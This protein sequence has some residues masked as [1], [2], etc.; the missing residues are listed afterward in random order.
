MPSDADRLV[1]NPGDSVGQHRVTRLIGRGGMGSVY[2][3][4]HTLLGRTVAIKVLL[5]E[6][7]QNADIVQRFFNEARATTAIHHPGIVEVF[8][9]G[10]TS[11]GAAYIVMEY[12]RGESLAARIESK[13]VSWA[14]AVV[15]MRQLA[16]VLAAAHAQG[17]V[18][19]DL[20]PDN[21][22]LVSDPEVPGGE[23]V[24]LLDFG[25][26][27]LLN[28][29]ATSNPTRTGSVLGTPTYMAP[30]QCRGVT[31]DHRA[32]LYAVGCVLFEL[33]TGRPPFDGEGSGDI[34]AAHIHV[35]PPLT[36]RF[37]SGVPADLEALVQAL[38]VKQPSQRLQTANELV[39]AIDGL[40]S[41]GTGAHAPMTVVMPTP[42]PTM[43]TTLSGAASARSTPPSPRN[44]YLTVGI[45]AVLATAAAG[46]VVV[47]R[48]DPGTPQQRL[49]APVAAP[50]ALVPIDVE[51]TP[52]GARVY[53]DAKLLGVTPFHGEVPR[54]AREATLEITLSGF[55]TQTLRV[56]VDQAIAQRIELE[57]TP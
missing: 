41:I 43:P 5:P 17:I 35:P 53:L 27:K 33:L 2:A 31:I 7:T 25:I 30:E 26:A 34:L 6:L 22:F 51:S 32:D 37:V 24:K 14:H 44:R 52:A 3:A 39:R 4:E 49:V 8:D 50:A 12:L 40:G 47:A 15:L 42:A 56:S 29:A 45:L 11:E 36:S 46:I 13:R 28:H 18:H 10:W 20:K 57:A 1:L 23:R 38:L 54:A 48:R 19:R 55:R 9:F 16:G 21:I